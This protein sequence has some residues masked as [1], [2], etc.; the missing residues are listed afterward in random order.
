M[1]VFG[2]IRPYR[3]E[4]LISLALLG[5]MAVLDL[6]IPRL[7]QRI[8]DQGIARGDEPLV[9]Q[10]AL[11]MLGISALST[12]TAIG[13]N[14]YS[15]RTGEGVARD[16]R[17]ALFLKI[18][19][20]A[21]ADLD[22]RQTGQLLV[23]LTSDIAAIKSLVQ[24][25]LR[26]GTRAPLMIAGSMILMI[27][28]SPQLA[29]ALL[30]VLLVTLGLIAFFIV[31]TEPLFRTVQSKLDVL[32]GVLQENIAGVR[33]VK[34]LVRGAYEVTRFARANAEMTDR[35]VAVMRFMSAMM[36]ALSLCLN[37]GMVV[38]IWSGGL[39][40]IRGEL[41]LGQIVAFGNYLLSTMSPLMMM[42]LLANTWASG[43]A[44]ADR[45]QEVLD[46]VPEVQDAPNARALPEGAAVRVELADVGFAYGADLEP[47]LREIALQAEPGQTIAI[48]GATGS[49]KSTLVALIPRFYDVT[50]GSVCVAGED[51]RELSQ[52]S[53]LS[54]IGVVP[55]ESLLFSGTVRENISYGRPSA[56]DAEVQAAA[57]AAQAH[58]FIE[59]LPGGYASRIAPRGSN[60]SGGQ[61]Q[62]LAIA[63]ALLL[64]PEV[65]ILDDSTSAVDVET[66][67]KIQD[68][69]AQHASQRIT[70]VV[71]QRI[72]T[73]LRADQI[74]V[75][76]RGRIVAR[77]THAELMQTS[78][79]YKEI[80]AS[81]L[82][83]GIL[84]SVRSSVEVAQ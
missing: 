44:S 31:K 8:I 62:R 24:I 70:F 35:S 29:L 64:D 39:S 68:A 6:A 61:R 34:A 15:V 42:S 18:Q 28:T 38:V 37:F 80:Y 17:E 46:V 57:Q 14:R 49:G 10:T 79:I 43:L 30:P 74:I 32:N 54:K 3:R 52:A 40:T 84:E 9:V 11:L 19:S 1:K 82:G 83:E 23:R 75:L 77:G 56:S 2:F 59:K 13:N 50:S 71:A 47:V 26:I 5:L 27:A 60:L 67:T 36:P 12:L 51:V 73:V 45:V 16:L 41:T 7:I 53:L 66:E 48:L 76:E 25:S 63:R 65:L 55:Q 33:L 58:E 22:R 21:F 20:F 69:L 72:S 78:A 81:Q 4:A